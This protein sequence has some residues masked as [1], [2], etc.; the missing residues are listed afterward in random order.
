MFSC[1][2]KYV[3]AFLGNIVKQSFLSTVAPSLQTLRETVLSSLRL[4]NDK[5]SKEKFIILA[6]DTVEDQVK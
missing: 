6:G 2:N 5:I 3:Y 4:A 1:N